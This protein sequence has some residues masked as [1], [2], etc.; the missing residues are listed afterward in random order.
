MSE[1]KDP[2]APEPRVTYSQWFPRTGTD[3]DR[4][5]RV[6][7]LL[8]GLRFELRP[9]PDPDAL[10][11]GHMIADKDGKLIRYPVRILR[12]SSPEAE[13]KPEDCPVHDTLRSEPD[14]ST[15]G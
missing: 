14:S 7:E 6:A 5:S 15:G 13:S 11:D 2:S 12:T 3:E 10:W 4:G 1:E 9:D 8:S